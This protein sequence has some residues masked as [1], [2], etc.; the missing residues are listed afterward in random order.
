MP[1]TTT[2][3]AAFAIAL[4]QSIP[5]PWRRMAPD[6][7][8]PVADVLDHRQVVADEDPRRPVAL[9]HRLEQVEY[10]A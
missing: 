1:T 6:D 5:F 3:A 10:L 8:D 4:G 7:D 9:L 2:V